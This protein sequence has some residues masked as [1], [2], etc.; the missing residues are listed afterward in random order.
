MTVPPNLQTPKQLLG[1]LAGSDIIMEC[2]IEAFPRPVN[3]WIRA[4]NTKAGDVISSELY[5]RPD[6]LL[7]GYF[8]ICIKENG[9][10]Y[11]LYIVFLYR[12]KHKIAEER[13]SLYE[14]KITLTVRNF[15]RTDLGTY[16]CIS[17]NSLGRA[18][19]TIRLYEIRIPTTIATTTTTKAT[20]TTRRSSLNFF[21][22][23]F[24][25][26]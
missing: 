9:F 4:S 16:T 5:V 22:C 15:T 7:D 2:L 13:L 24:H 23:V 19:T 21:F 10:S 17:T 1:G 8:S 25:I 3:Y 12:K 14:I 18:N 26:F 20:T 6:M 11:Y